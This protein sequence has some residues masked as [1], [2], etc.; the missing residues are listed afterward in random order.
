[1]PTPEQVLRDAADIVSSRGET[2]GDWRENMTNT[3]ELWSSFLRQPIT[4]EQ[5]CTMMVLVK[6]SRI[7]CG[8]FNIDDYKDV[9]G[10]GAIAG[11]LV[12]G[13]ESKTN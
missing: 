8:K 9:L 3:A 4:P 7:A 11:A 1:M 5:V 12:S 6:V 10:Y 13:E 2:H